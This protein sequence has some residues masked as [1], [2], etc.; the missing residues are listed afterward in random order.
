LSSSTGALSILA[1]SH[2]DAY[3]WNLVAENGR[4]L[5]ASLEAFATERDA[6][7]GARDA[8][9]LIASAASPSEGLSGS[10]DRE[11]RHV[12]RAGPDFTGLLIRRS[13]RRSATRSMRGSST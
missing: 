8:R 10:V 9:D 3:R 11:R 13:F 5:A 6:E 4:I 12:D 2:A 7:R 1:A